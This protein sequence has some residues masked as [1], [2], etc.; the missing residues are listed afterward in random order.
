MTAWGEIIL[1]AVAL[2]TRIVAPAAKDQPAD[3][4]TD[5]ARQIDHRLPSDITTVIADRIFYLGILDHR[6]FIT[7]DDFEPSVQDLAA[8]QPWAL[9]IT[10]T[11]ETDN[12]KPFAAMRAY[13]ATTGKAKAYCFYRAG[14]QFAVYLPREKLPADAPIGCSTQ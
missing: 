12:D 2:P 13:A 1:M 8:P 3:T 9:I 4:F 10:S 5:L 14:Y 7:I 11:A 6:Q